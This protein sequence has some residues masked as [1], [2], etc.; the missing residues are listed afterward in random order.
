ML[1]GELA[2]G[3]G[4]TYRLGASDD[5]AQQIRLTGGRLPRSCTPQRC[6]VLLTGATSP[7]RLESSLGIV[8]VGTGVRTD[9]LLL[10]GTF[11][12]GPGAVVLLG[13]DPDALQRLSALEQFPRGSGWVAA[14]DPGH[15]ASLGVPA[16]ADLSR[17][18]SD[19][20]ALEIRALVLS[21][22]DDALLSADARAAASRSRFALLGG[23]TAV[24]VLGFVLVA[25][26][27]LRREHREVAALLRRRG[28]SSASVLVFAALGAGA[29]VVAG[30]VLGTAS[31][32]L[33]AWLAAGAQPLHP[34]PAELATSS[35]LDALPALV[36]LTVTGVVL[37]TTVLVW[38]AGQ[39]RTAWHVVELLAV[40]TTATAVLVA[41]RGAVGVAS[42]GGDP[43][44]I[45]LPVL[46]LTAAAL[47]AA[48]LWV[49]V[50]SFVSRRLPAPAVAARLAAASGVRR[51]LRTVVTVGFVTA[52]VG[53]VVFAGS[54]R[55]TLQSGSA[56]TAA[57]DVPTDAR[58]TVG[59]QGDDPLA[60]QARAPLP[61][62]EHAVLR[63]VAGVRTSATSGDAV[64]V[65][66]VDDDVLPLLARWDR[67]VGASSPSS[68]AAALASA[69]PPS[70]IALA[71][72][73]RTLTIPV[74]SWTRNETGD[75]EITAWV[76]APDGR[77]QGVSLVQRDGVL[78]G[79]LPD[80]GSG[81][82]L[83]GLTMRENS[84]DATRR[85]HRVGEGG[86]VAAF[87]AGRLVLGP[88]VGA[89]TSWPAWSSR[90]AGVTA[91][92]SSLSLSYELTGPLVV[93][94]PGLA[95][96]PPVRVVTDA[97]TASRGSTL[98]LDLGGGDAVA[99]QVVGTLPRFPTAGPRFLVADRVALAAALDDVSPGSGAPHE[100][101]AESCELA[102]CPGDRPRR[103][104]V[105][106]SGRGHPGAA[107]GGPRVRCRG[108]GRGM[109]AARRGRGVAAG[110]DRLAGAA[111]D[112][113]TAGRR[114]SAPRARGGRCCH[115]DAASQP[116]VAGGRRR[117]PGAP[118]RHRGGTRAHPLGV[119]PRRALGR[120][121]LAH[122][123]A[124][125]VR[126]SGVDRGRPP[127]RARGGAGGLRG[128]DRP[129]AA[130]GLAGATRPG[131][132]MSAPGG[133]AVDVHDLFCL[134]DAPTGSVAA[135][136]G[137]SLRVP[138]GERLVVHGPNGSGK[139]TLL[140]VLAAEVAPSAGS[141]RVVGV[142]LAG[143]DDATRTALR[144]DRLGLV[145][146]RA[147]RS[148]RP[149]LDV[150]DNVALQLRVA[151]RG[152]AEA[153]ASAREALSRL[154]LEHL[155]GRR[156][157][158]LS[159]GEAQR[160]AVAAA[161]AHRP[162]VVLA[163]EPTGEL[164]AR[165]ADEV[166]DVL[167]TAVRDL[168][169][170]LVLVT[171]DPRA[172][173]IADRVVRIRDGRL[174]EQWDP[175]TPHS[176]TLVVD[177]RG[178]VRLPDAL[179]QR[180]GALAGAVAV[181]TADGV[182]LRG[183][184]QASD[185]PTAAAPAPA[186]DADRGDV[187]ATLDD[188]RVGFGGTAVLDGITLELRGGT[189]AVVSGRSGSGKSTLL[190]ALTGL[191]PV[192]SGDVTL[193]GRR[194]AELDRDGRAAV[195]RSGVTVAAQGGSL[196]ET[197]HVRDNLEL[198]RTARGLPPDDALV[199][200]LC[201]GLGLTPLGHRPVSSLSGGERQ[202]VAVARALVV[203]PVVAVLDE[204]T[205]QLDE[206]GAETVARALVAAARRGCAVVV[207]SHDPVL[208][209]TADLLVDLARM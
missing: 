83:V 85:Q 27:G 102:R 24:L 68:I 144:R 166:Y 80:L 152:R 22:P 81:L 62:P 40:A 98:R 187:V 196:V 95:D 179:R 170:T 33:A 94:R 54:Y 201:D 195:R 127:R 143:A 42:V 25:A 7:P 191:A 122:P 151:G 149:E 202:R 58:I 23:A 109:A 29:A 41:A 4:D 44:A 77:E 38:P 12:P 47:V 70:G 135:L 35:V 208:L 88:P 146:Q 117:G 115:L 5:L 204:P 39:E 15:I 45:A 97:E 159:G 162:G 108:P 16:Y 178:W 76:A 20:L 132:A 110:R 26:V 13:S 34:P 138:V 182:L 154:G 75:V 52:A 2:D 87:L 133:P 141:V 119:D 8:V 118:G 84:A 183:T 168:A 6:E 120:R 164:D 71:Q 113:R 157:E 103:T 165:A 193:L 78:T 89:T 185:R 160:V 46:S 10:P 101:W 173:R 139:S 126:G 99:A 176:E 169:A 9:P 11:D 181:T 198:A 184:G 200:A 188:V 112:G 171:H 142:D 53:S 90:T 137:M 86:T 145:D 121:H 48:R 31:G 111:R 96:R 32:W 18:V 158:T 189:L 130:R 190:R 61:G 74:V 205:S 105:G 140:A 129:D 73:T 93:V 64:Q 136:R 150:V 128:R 60:L 148:L 106:P 43:L 14:L 180:H 37:T 206:A 57:F 3:V 131:H 63:T 17:Q 174:S 207:A 197:L 116:V 69:A 100:I 67:T 72:G 175:A 19:D 123:A 91:T 163:D 125:P 65:L 161:L 156:P 66:G 186:A 153:R 192:D 114:R 55:A 155:G 28:A 203:E 82:T 167:A 172:A 51:P 79:A 49:P 30:A 50:A 194:L 124:A 177:D 21:V 92:A 104:A 147:R 134:Y 107:A 59:P 36:L 56:D 199:D 1:F 209:E